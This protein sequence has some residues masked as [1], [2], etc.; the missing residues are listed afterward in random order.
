MT[1]DIVWSI[2]DISNALMAIPNLVAVVGLSGVVVKITDNY[3][4]RKKGMNIEPMLSAYPEL[5]A[6]FV[7]ALAEEENAE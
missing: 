6:E 2:S 4:K 3:F 7:K 1:S 5:N